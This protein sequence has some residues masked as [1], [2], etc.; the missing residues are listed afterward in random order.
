MSDLKFEIRLWRMWDILTDRKVSE[1]TN[2][3]SM[4]FMSGLFS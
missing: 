2:V 1:E 4:P 3:T